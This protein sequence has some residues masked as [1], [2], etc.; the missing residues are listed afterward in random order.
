MILANQ[1]LAIL[2]PVLY[3]YRNER[4]KLGTGTCSTYDK[5]AR[6]QSKREEGK[7]L[8]PVPYVVCIAYVK[9]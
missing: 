7:A 1:N 3:E 9:R 2:V 6:V 4:G 8:V 5:W